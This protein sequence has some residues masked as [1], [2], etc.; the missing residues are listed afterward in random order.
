MWVLLVV[1]ARLVARPRAA[2]LRSCSAVAEHEDVRRVPIASAIS[3]VAP[4]QVPMVSAP[5]S[6]NFM[7]PVPEA[8]VPAVEICSERSAAGMISSASDTP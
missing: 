5:L 6:A 1:Q 7:L 8:S 3:M 2:G 4:S